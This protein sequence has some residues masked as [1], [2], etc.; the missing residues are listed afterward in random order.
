MK[1]YIKYMLML[2]IL[3]VL[4]GIMLQYFLND[5]WDNFKTTLSGALSIVITVTAHYLDS[6]KKKD[7]MNLTGRYEPTE[8]IEREEEAI[9]KN[10]ISENITYVTGNSGIGKTFLLSKIQNDINIQNIC[11]GYCA[12]YFYINNRYDSPSKA[13]SS[14]LLISENSSIDQIIQTINKLNQRKNPVLIFDYAPDFIVQI[15]EFARSISNRDIR[16]RII[17]GCSN[18]QD[19]KN[20]IKLTVFSHNDIQNLAKKI[21]LQ[22]EN[23]VIKKI[24]E[25]SSGLP[26]FIS[27]LVKDIASGNNKISLNTCRNIKEYLQMKFNELDNS[28]QICLLALSFY[29][30][31]D[32]HIKIDELQNIFSEVNSYNLEILNIKS[33]ITKK[34]NDVNIDKS[35]AQILRDYNAEQRHNIINKLAIAYKF[36]K[37]RKETFLF[38]LLGNYEVDENCFKES[39]LRF[40]EEKNYAYIISMSST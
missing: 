32:S 33:F 35:V 28:V 15:D 24:H 36:M 34:T 29:A 20:A 7:S 19:K 12:Y 4:I 10:A 8:Y 11:K 26:V 37:K 39:L 16:Y 38:T 5:Y 25:T 21:N 23:N 27:Y 6:K 22:L 3:Y 40:Y 9:V 13:V 2:V 14:Q 30:I 18:A 1:K 17:I 31:Y